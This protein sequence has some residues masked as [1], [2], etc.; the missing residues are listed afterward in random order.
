VR[1]N[2]PAPITAASSAEIFIGFINAALGLRA[3]FFFAG[4]FTAAFFAAFFFTAIVFSPLKT[5]KTPNHWVE[6]IVNQIPSGSAIP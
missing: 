5:Q 2:G 6:R 1:G 4:F 3:D